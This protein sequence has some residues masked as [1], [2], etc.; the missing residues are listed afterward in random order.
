MT[1]EENDNEPDVYS[2]S[3]RCLNISL[4]LLVLSIFIDL[5]RLNDLPLFMILNVMLSAGAVVFGAF[6]LIATYKESCDSDKGDD[7][8]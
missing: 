4:A 1:M 6:A 7:N 2:K 8:D 3:D 5:T